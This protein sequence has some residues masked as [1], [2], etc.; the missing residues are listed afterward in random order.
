MQ[1]VARSRVLLLAIAVAALFTGCVKRPP[2]DEETVAYLRSCGGGFFACRYPQLR[3][4]SL[5]APSA[6]SDTVVRLFQAHW[7]HIHIGRVERG[8]TGWHYVYKSH[9]EGEDAAPLHADSLLIPSALVDSLLATI[10]SHNYWQ[11]GAAQC[12]GGQIDGQ[13]VTLEVRIGPQ[14]HTVTCSVSRSAPLPADVAAT[15][16]SL[17]AIASWVPDRPRAP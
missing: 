9:S 8:R 14:Y 3:E 12:T 10:R 15:L 7:Y 11:T 2:S 17:H 1:T 6:T 16:A 5:A 13:S 4:R